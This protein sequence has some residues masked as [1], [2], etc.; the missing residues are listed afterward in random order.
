ML[1]HLEHN[2]AEDAVSGNRAPAG[3]TSDSTVHM[4]SEF[5]E[6]KPTSFEHKIA[7]VWIQLFSARQRSAPNAYPK[8]GCGAI[9][10]SPDL[11]AFLFM[12]I[13]AAD[14]L[15]HCAGRQGECSTCT[16]HHDLSLTREAAE[17]LS[18]C[19]K[20]QKA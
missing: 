4:A 20:S 18:S 11:Y 16:E 15:Q 6:Q 12:Y 14:S 13:P 1:H 8:R 7:L 3:W 2:L 9:V 17:Q 10:M 19:Q 5:A